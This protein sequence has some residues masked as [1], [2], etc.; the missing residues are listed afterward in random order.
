MTTSSE[1]APTRSVAVPIRILAGVSVPDT[2]LVVQAIE[3]ARNASEP[4]LFNHVMRC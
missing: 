3:Y 1:R 2:P 4:Y